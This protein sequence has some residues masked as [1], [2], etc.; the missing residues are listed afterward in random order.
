MSELE[1]ERCVIFGGLSAVS[2]VEK[3]LMDEVDGC[4][5]ENKPGDPAGV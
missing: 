3:V 1:L 5:F 2:M 4:V